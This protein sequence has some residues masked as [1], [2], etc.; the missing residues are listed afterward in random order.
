MRCIL[1]SFPD[2][3]VQHHLG[4]PCMFS[5]QEDSL[6]SGDLGSM[7]WVSRSIT[8]KGLHLLTQPH[9]SS[10][11]QECPSLCLVQLQVQMWS[12]QV[13]SLSLKEFCKNFS[14]FLCLCFFFLVSNFYNGDQLVFTAVFLPLY[15]Y[16]IHLQRDIHPQIIRF[17]LVRYILLR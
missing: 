8:L 2:H 17:L 15:T 3:T 1:E 7:E 16:L 11:P 9:Q 10:D 5:L 4:F 13:P 14:L 6:E 12:I